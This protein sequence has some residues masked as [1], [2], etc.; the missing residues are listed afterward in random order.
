M[1]TENTV[2]F[3]LELRKWNEIIYLSSSRALGKLQIILFLITKFIE[4]AKYSQIP[5]EPQ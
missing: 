4:D 1:N 5:A 2:Q 3:L